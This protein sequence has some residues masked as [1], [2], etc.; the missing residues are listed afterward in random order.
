[1]RK[2]ILE[3]LRLA[4]EASVSTIAGEYIRSRMMHYA[5]TDDF[6]FYLATMKGDPKVI[7]ITHNPSISLMILRKVGD[8]SKFMDLKEFSQ[9][10]EIEVQGKAKI[11]KDKEEREK[12]LRLLS[13]RTPVV[14]LLREKG[15]DH[16]L[17]VI[18]VEPH[19]IRYK[20]VA[21][22]LQGKPP[23]VLEFAER[24]TVFDEFKQLVEKLRTWYIAIRAPFLV[25][26]VPPVA[27]GALVAL[28]FKGIFD[29]WLFVLTLLGVVLANVAVNL[30]NDYFDHKLLTDLV[31][32]EFV[33]PFSGG[34]RV[35]Q[36][37]L[38]TPLEVLS[39]GFVALILSL[40]IGIYLSL[41]SGFLVLMLALLGFLSM[42][43]YNVPPLRLS[44]RGL[45]EL[46][47]GLN[48]GVLVSLG[49]YVVQTGTIELEPLIPSIPLALLISLILLVNEFPDYNADKATGRRTL[50]V[51]LGPKKA[52]W[53]YLA[54]ASL[55]YIYIAVAVVIGA[56]PS[57]TILALLSL[58][59]TAYALKYLFRY[60]RSPFDMI[61][62]YVA[63][64]LS[65]ISVGFLLV[66]S[67]L[68]ISVSSPIIIASSA[69]LILTYVVYEY[70]HIRRDLRAFLTMKKAVRT[71]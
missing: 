44:G 13:E 47:V 19:V 63:T 33:R 23:V 35:I 8:P 42:L 6:V 60:Y 20:V 3:D 1:M 65:Y 22:I 70:Y 56:A 62:S 46:L 71:V 59:I 16:V 53:I 66:A 9:W 26:G 34:S 57:Y 5:V 27:L 29:P 49:S 64:I 10:R 69:I 61:P 2:E 14:K 18:R 38:L 41:R 11:V 52:R 24:R 50:V 21:D 43:A 7:H 39:G 37:G 55:T 45:G 67:Y 51:I 12:A 17:D 30:L 15:Q 54:L 25:A 4:T 58:P 31:N 32:V 40:A 28:G 48:F 68:V 36:L